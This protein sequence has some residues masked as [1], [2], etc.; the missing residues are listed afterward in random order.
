MWAIRLA[1]VAVVFA[2][3][4]AAC[5]L[6]A[7]VDDIPSSTEAI[8]LGNGGFDMGPEAPAFGRQ[9][10]LFAGHLLDFGPDLAPPEPSADKR[11]LA[12]GTPAAAM[13]AV[14]VEWGRIP[15]DRDARDSVDWSGELLVSRGAI[16]V[17]RT[18]LFEPD[19]DAVLPRA[20]SRAVRFRS[21]TGPHHDGLVITLVDPRPDSREPLVLSYSRATAT[22]VR[23]LAVDVRVADLLWLPAQLM[24]DDRG[25]RMIAVGMPLSRPACAQ[26]FV[27]GRWEGR[28]PGRGVLMGPVVDA[29]GEL[30]GHLRGRY[31]VRRSG[32]RVFHGKYIG[33]DGRARGI[34]KGHHGDGMFGGEWIVGEREVGWVR[35]RYTDARA[36][37][38]PRGGFLGT[39][40]ARSCDSA[41]PPSSAEP[42]GHAEPPAHDDADRDGHG[43]RA[44]GR[45]RTPP[46]RE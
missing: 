36:A 15:G 19:A 22:G 35:G 21:M 40:G 30:N 6:D 23:T 13:Y 24:H 14:L 33:V 8:E 32:E 7:G 38:E 4:G 11:A 31:G 27:A 3:G 43:G 34:F 46:G 12:M 29:R 25:N 39:W 41:A 44:S 28:G 42:D 10:E 16:V 2:V 26:G 9:A 1:V 18:V 17:E 37:A 45:S 20:A 5:V